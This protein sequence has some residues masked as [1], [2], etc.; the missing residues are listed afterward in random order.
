MQYTHSACVNF[1]PRKEPR[2]VLLIKKNNKKKNPS[3]LN[4]D[5]IL[6]ALKLTHTL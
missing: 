5:A 2:Q 4:K 3:M 1:L 6:P